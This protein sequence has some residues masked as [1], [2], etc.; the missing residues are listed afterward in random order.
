MYGRP[1]G[2]KPTPQA[3]R[4]ARERAEMYR[5]FIPQWPALAESFEREAAQIEA[6]A[7]EAAA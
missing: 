1:N 2:V 4:Q 5:H 3:A 6:A 7:K